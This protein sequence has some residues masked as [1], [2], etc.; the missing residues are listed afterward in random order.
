MQKYDWKY[1]RV[2]EDELVRTIETQSDTTRV[3]ITHSDNVAHAARC[4]KGENLRRRQFVRWNLRKQGKS[5]KF[6]LNTHPDYVRY[7]CRR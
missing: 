1:R 4:Y 3:N 7:G 5:T 2:D 6:E